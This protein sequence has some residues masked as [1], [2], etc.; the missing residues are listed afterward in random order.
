MANP[1]TEISWGTPHKGGDITVDRYGL[2]VG[3]NCHGCYSEELRETDDL[4]KLRDAIN[5]ILT[6]RGVRR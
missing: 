6:H 2:I 3:T 1:P 5:A 4:I